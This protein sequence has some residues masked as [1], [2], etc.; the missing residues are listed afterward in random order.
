M[1][2]KVV[3]V[4]GGLVGGLKGSKVIAIAPKK[5]GRPKMSDDIALR[6]SERFSVTAKESEALNELA[7]R[8]GF[9]TTSELVRYCIGFT[10]K[11]LKGKPIHEFKQVKALDSVLAWQQISDSIRNAIYKDS[12]KELPLE[13]SGK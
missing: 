13:F 4:K 5:R 1:K 11:T 8:C 12:S 2:A 3:K 6:H 9:D 7:L 10:V